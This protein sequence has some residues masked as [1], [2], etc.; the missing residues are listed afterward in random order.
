[1]KGPLIINIHHYQ[2]QSALGRFYQY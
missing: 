1:M 2:Y